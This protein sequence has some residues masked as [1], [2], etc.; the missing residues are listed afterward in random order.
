MWYSCRYSITVD[1]PAGVQTY[2]FVLD[3]QKWVHDPA[4][5]D[6]DGYFHDSVIAVGLK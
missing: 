6:Q 1:L 5:P 3:G 2:K 4:N